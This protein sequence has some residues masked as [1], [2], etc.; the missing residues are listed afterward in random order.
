MIL[1][2]IYNEILYILVDR[3]C[4]KYSV[5]GVYMTPHTLKYWAT[6]AHDHNHDH[7]MTSYINSWSCYENPQDSSYSL[8][9]KN[10]RKSYKTGG[11]W[12]KIRW[13]WFFWWKTKVD[14]FCKCPLKKLKTET[15]GFKIYSWDHSVGEAT[16]FLET[17]WIIYCTYSFRCN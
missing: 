17:H 10:Q 15:N 16:D 11:C 9:L 1:M 2:Y 6:I 3:Y 5:M 13:S 7:V 4:S 8:S 14:L 12:I